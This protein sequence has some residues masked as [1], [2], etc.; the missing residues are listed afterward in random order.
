MMCVVNISA[1]LR[2]DELLVEIH[3]QIVFV[4]HGGRF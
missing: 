3:T 1:E 2:D 4:L